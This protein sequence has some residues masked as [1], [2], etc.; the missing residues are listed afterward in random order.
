MYTQYLDIKSFIEYL[1]N[2]NEKKI[3]LFLNENIFCINFL[4]FYIEN[5]KL[6]IKLKKKCLKNNELNLLKKIEC[7]TI[8]IIPLKEFFKNSTISGFKMS[9]NGCVIACMK[10][11]D[12]S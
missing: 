7:N 8:P 11:S 5:S 3:R 4:E 10:P 9:P 12:K 1:T 2:S 6:N